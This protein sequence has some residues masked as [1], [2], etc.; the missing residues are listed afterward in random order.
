[1]SLKDTIVQWSQ[2]VDLALEGKLQEAIDVWSAMQE[3]G[4]KIYFN[5]ACMHM[6]LGSID[7]AERV[8]GVN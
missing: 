7:N 2:G 3:P 4:A 6:L 8:S 5:I 1:M